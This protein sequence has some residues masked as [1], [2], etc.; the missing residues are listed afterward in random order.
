ML[1]G[2]QYQNIRQSFHK[3]KIVG[4]IDNVLSLPSWAA[5]GGDHV[6][7]T[8]KLV[9]GEALLVGDVVIQAW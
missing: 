9:S 3:R 4:M 7:V 1:N 5:V 8:C 2:D 6:P